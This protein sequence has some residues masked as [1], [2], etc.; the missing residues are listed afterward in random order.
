MTAEEKP[1]K[2]ESPESSLPAQTPPGDIQI[3][4]KWRAPLPPPQIFNKYETEVRREITAGMTREQ[5][6]RHKLEENEQRHKHKME[7]GAAVITAL[8]L[9][10]ILASGTAVTIST[11]LFRALW[12]ALIVVFLPALVAIGRGFLSR[13]LAR[14]KD[15]PPNSPGA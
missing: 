13:L 5:L 10:G 11:G 6:H 1:Q 2:E 12:V 14:K 7:G 8:L 9:L 15:K 4:A 3:K